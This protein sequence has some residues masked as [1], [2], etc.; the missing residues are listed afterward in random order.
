[1]ANA[2]FRSDHLGIYHDRRNTFL[3]NINRN[4]ILI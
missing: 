4:I 3:G 1:M 2:V